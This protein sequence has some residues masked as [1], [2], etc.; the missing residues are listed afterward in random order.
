M[1]GFAWMIVEVLSSFAWGAQL[2]AI[3]ILIG[4]PRGW[5][6]WVGEFILDAGMIPFWIIMAFLTPAVLPQDGT[7]WF[8]TDMSVAALYGYYAWRTWYRNRKGKWAPGWSSM[9]VVDLGGRLG[10]EPQ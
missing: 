8:F 7:F 5:P 3:I 2:I 10:L 6:R 4:L 9:L 1:P